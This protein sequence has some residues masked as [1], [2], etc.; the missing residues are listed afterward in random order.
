MNKLFKN[1]PC[2]RSID[3]LVAY[4]CILPPLPLPLLPLS[5]FMCKLCLLCRSLIRNGENLYPLQYL[6]GV[7]LK[8]S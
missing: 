5:P 4:G 3:S 8:E 7:F 2:I 6:C 1:M